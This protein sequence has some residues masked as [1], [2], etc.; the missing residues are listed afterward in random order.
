MIASHRLHL[1]AL[2]SGVP[3]PRRGMRVLVTLQAMIDKS[4]SH[5]VTPRVFVLGGYIASVSNWEQL[6]DAWQ[7]ILDAPPKLRFF[8][9]KDAFPTSGK[10][11]GVFNNFTEAQR[12]SKVAQFREIIEEY[13]YAEFGIGFLADAYERAFSWSR[14]HAKN[15]YLYAV[16]L[17]TSELP[18]QMEQLGLEKQQLDL[19]FDNRVIEEPKILNA[20]IY[21]KKN[22][23]PNPPD[24]FTKVFV[25]APVFR[26]KLDVIALQTADMFVGWV[27][28][29]NIADLNGREPLSLPGAKRGIRHMYIVPTEEQLR[30]LAEEKRQLL[31]DKGLF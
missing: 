8:S 16:P 18:R 10:P 27:R 4:D 5:G 25:N 13:V 24:A 17:L 14:V 30:E 12:D 22:S 23:I 21:T 26:S 19:I 29:G 20:W 2:V 9:F 3:E 6:T 7:R 28:V 1:H 11:R 31:I 15:P